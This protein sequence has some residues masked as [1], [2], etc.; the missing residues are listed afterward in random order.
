MITFSEQFTEEPIGDRGVTLFG[1]MIWIAMV[2]KQ[3]YRS[4]DRVGGEAI[5]ATMVKM[6]G[7]IVVGFIHYWYFCQLISIHEIIYFFKETIYVQRIPCSNLISK[8]M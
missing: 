3:M 8:H 7:S 1:L 6:P 2:M 4:V 5:T